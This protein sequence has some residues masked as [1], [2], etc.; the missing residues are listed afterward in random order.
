MSENTD[1]RTIKSE[2]TGSTSKRRVPDDLGP[3]FDM[4]GGVD[5]LFADRKIGVFVKGCR[6]KTNM[7][8]IIWESIDKCDTERCPVAQGCE[9]I[10]FCQDG[11]CAIQSKYLESVMSIIFRAIEKKADEMTLMEVGFLLIPLFN[12]LVKLKIQ[13]VGLQ[14]KIVEYTKK[15]PV[16]HPLLRE[17]RTCISTIKST[18][19]D[20]LK[21]KDGN[22][23]VGALPTSLNMAGNDQEGTSDYY[24]ML[25]QTSSK[26][27]ESI[28]GKM[29]KADEA[30]YVVTGA[31]ARKKYIKIDDKRIQQ[32]MDEKRMMDE[33]SAQED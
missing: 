3:T 11:K 27:G 32:E 10:G 7:A 23:A 26:P 4:G 29:L 15:G 5:D 20:V 8:L 33:E 30:Q 14:G 13:E 1:R 22:D 12:Q 28:P 21:R 25:R 31:N 2:A 16:I 19:N 6:G 18:M 17:I 24:A 9:Y